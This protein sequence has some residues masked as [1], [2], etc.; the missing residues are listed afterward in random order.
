MKRF[1]RRLFN[2]FAAV[3]LVLCMASIILWVRS[4][5]CVDQIIS[6]TGPWRWLIK[7][8]RGTL[9]IG[10]SRANPSAPP[11]RWTWERLAFSD[12]G[13]I[14]SHPRFFH[15][16]QNGT[17]WAISIPLW[18]LILC[19]LILPSF[20]LN[21][22][23]RQRRRQRTGLCTSCGYDLR[24]TPDRCPECGTIPLKKEIISK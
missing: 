5:S 23:C 18:F 17:G 8:G 19:W 9:Q 6:G 22:R 7:L 10:Q 16:V 11:L 12:H 24:A 4:F 21:N 15:Y 20:F 2:W 3:S 13:I 14:S 1:R